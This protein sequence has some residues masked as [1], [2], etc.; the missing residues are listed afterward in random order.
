V[1]K[2]R[3]I[4]KGDRVLYDGL[5]GIVEDVYETY[6]GTPQLSLVSELDEEITCSA[7]TDKCELLTEDQEIDQ[8][9][10]LN[11]ARFNSELIRFQVD[12]LTDK[13]FRDGNH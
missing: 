7:D 1:S 4:K 11:E 3:Q 6:A 9:S 12:R 2:E 10:A 5:V 13:Y 8:E